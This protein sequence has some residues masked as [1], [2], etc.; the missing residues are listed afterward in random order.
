MEAQE[1]LN[2]APEG[3]EGQ[4]AED[5]AKVAD[6]LPK[7]AALSGQAH[8]RTETSGTSEFNK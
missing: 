1:L 2:Q 7:I 3:T 4:Q 6:I 8:K 5:Q